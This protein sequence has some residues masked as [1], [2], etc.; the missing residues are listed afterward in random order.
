MKL[1]IKKSL[2]TWFT[3][4][5]KHTW[6]SEQLSI[7]KK[8][9][10]ISGNTRN[11]TIRKNN[12]KLLLNTYYSSEIEMFGWSEELLVLLIMWNRHILYKMIVDKLV[13]I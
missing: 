8:L 4:N 13:C 3:R 6:K 5:L 9:V 12:P 1:S 10:L 2:V 11:L 7:I